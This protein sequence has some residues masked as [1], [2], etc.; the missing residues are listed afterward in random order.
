MQGVTKRNRLNWLFSVSCTLFTLSSCVW[1]VLKVSLWKWLGFVLLCKFPWIVVWMYL[2]VWVRVS[3]I[4]VISVAL[5]YWWGQ[6]EGFGKLWF[7]WFGPKIWNASQICVSS[8]HD[9][10]Q[11]CGISKIFTYIRIFFHAGS[12]DIIQSDFNICV[13]VYLPHA[14]T[15]ST[16]QK[17]LSA[18]N[19]FIYEQSTNHIFLNKKGAEHVSANTR[20]YQLYW[21]DHEMGTATYLMHRMLIGVSHVVILLSL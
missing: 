1:G 7:H 4:D 5:W 3:N 15:M 13:Y 21:S 19:N 9:K 12:Q 17:C 2:R 14:C 8:W 6:Y 10:V 11:S 18:V 16:I 20:P